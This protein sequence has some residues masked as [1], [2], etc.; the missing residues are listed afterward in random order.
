MGTPVC[1]AH[2]E[3]RHNL[4]SKELVLLVCYSCETD[5]RMHLQL[6]CL[7][8]FL[9]FE[10]ISQLYKQGKHTQSNLRQEEV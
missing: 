4:I 10:F 9:K 6:F 1:S 2:R 5:A 8:S 3:S 7:C